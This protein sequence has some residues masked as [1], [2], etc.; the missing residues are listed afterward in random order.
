MTLQITEFELNKYLLAE[1]GPDTDI[2]T[3]LHST[4]RS[5]TVT[6]DNI[7]YRSKIDACKSLMISCYKLN[8][9]ISCSS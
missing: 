1:P 7:T 9:I 5:L 2:R 3:Y 8:G 4:K 6:I